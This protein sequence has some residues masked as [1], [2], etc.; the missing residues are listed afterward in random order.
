MV[1]MCMEHVVHVV[2]IIA[3]KASHPCCASSGCSIVCLLSLRIVASSGNLPLQYVNSEICT[4]RSGL[5]ES[6]G[7]AFG[8]TPSVHMISGLSLA[9]HVHLGR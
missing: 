1:G 6:G 7:L 8:G 4:L 2:K 9:W 3:K 5:G